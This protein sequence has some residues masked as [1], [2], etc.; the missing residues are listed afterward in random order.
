[1]NP[2]LLSAA[3]VAVL[4]LLSAPSAA[5]V[6]TPSDGFRPPDASVAT[7]SDGL[8]LEINPA[9][10]G[11]VSRPELGY[12]FELASENLRGVANEAHSFFLAGG[13]G[14]LGAGV[15][16]QWLQKP[17]L[18]GDLQTYRKFTFGA[19][20]AFSRLAFGVG[21]NHFGSST[22]ER[23]DGLMGFDLG[24]QFRASRWLGV[25]LLLRDANGPFVRDDR[26]VPTRL[27]GSVA[28]RFWGGR[29]VVEQAAS[30]NFRDRYVRLIPRLTVE[31]I[32][33]LRLFAASDFLLARV[34]DMFRWSWDYLTAGFEVSLG[35]IG[36]AYAV[37]LAEYPPTD[38]LQFSTLSAYHWVSP[39]KRAPLIPLS[40]RWIYINL[41]QSFA[42]SPRSGLFQPKTRSFLSLARELERIASASDVDGVVINVAR[43][44]GYGQTWELRQLLESINRAGKT[45]IAVMP[46]SSLRA[47]YLAS[48][49][50]SVWHVPSSVVEPMGMRST[51]MS[52]SEAFRKL[53]V[54]AQFVRIGDYK[55]APEMYVSD[56]P[57]DA[58]I[59]QREAYVD[60]LWG[61][62]LAQISG[63]RSKP[64][65]E[66][67]SLITKLHLPHEAQAAGLI[68][69]VV[70]P[71][72]VERLVRVEYGASLEA[73]YQERPPIDAQW[74]GG[75]EIAVVPIE[76]DIVQGDSTGSLPLIG[77]PTAGARSI[78]RTLEALRT[79]PRVRAVVVRIDT[80]GGS[81]VASDTIFRALRRVA[82]TK[83]VIASMGD[84]ATSGGYYV[85]AGADE[86]FVTPT[87][88]TG[89]IGIFSG[90]VNAGQLA[91][92]LGINTSAI[93]RGNPPT[94]SDLFSPWTEQELA[95]VSTGLT[96]LYQLFLAQVATT[97]PLTT[98]QIDAVARGRVWAGTDALAAKL[99]DEQGGVVAAVRRAEELAGLDVGEA[100]VKLYTAGGSRVGLD[101]DLKVQAAKLLGLDQPGALEQLLNRDTMLTATIRETAFAWSIPLFYANGEALML[102]ETVVR[103]D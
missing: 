83:P 20:A 42:E 98:E 33:G 36:A 100:K 16:A 102:P 62:M 6:L 81:A 69:R 12:G 86:I 52:L 44:L 14:W 56:E 67:E 59:A 41:D 43:G 7:T 10:L 68:D 46:N 24:L 49:A 74:P 91:T 47:Y 87:T 53:G 66:L 78:Q 97:R 11:F 38:G 34:G 89:S 8:S 101:V 76:G 103:L 93:T 96:Y 32:H 99:A 71:D 25:G 94:F 90:K 28:L 35:S 40:K 15:A 88:I 63:S 31:P 84:L 2:R 64:V 65:A 45:T 80:P 3:L 95:D 57:T 1:M 51:S 4:S 85:A 82:A 61:T 19:A 58:N 70:Y 23:L 73:G 50:S 17:S 75:P 5:Q 37:T 26:S 27:D 72:E 48:A 22:D 79:N 9:G 13:T 54:E 39:G 21:L 77:R 55:S 18:G 30:T 92:R 29:L 60:A